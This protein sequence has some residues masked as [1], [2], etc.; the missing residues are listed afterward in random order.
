MPASGGE[1]ASISIYGKLFTAAVFK[2]EEVKFRIFFRNELKTSFPPSEFYPKPV[3][4]LIFFSFCDRINTGS[5]NDHL[6]I[7][8][9]K[10]VVWA[11]LVLR[12]LYPA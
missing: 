6:F 4:I 3:M 9:K 10:V 11:S 12:L 2:N 8:W 1:K 7:S 5:G